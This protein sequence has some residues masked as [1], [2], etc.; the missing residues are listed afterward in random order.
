MAT[1]SNFFRDF[2][3]ALEPPV[4]QHLTNVY[5]CLAL[6]TVVAGFGAYVDLVTKL[7]STSFIAAIAGVGL[8][9]GVTS[10]HD[11]GKNRY[12]RLGLLLGF[13]FCSGLGLGTLIDYAIT[14][15]PSIIVTA[16]ISTAAIFI[17]FSVA[18]L[19]AERGRWLY[20]GG[21]LMTF[22]AVLIGLSFAN[23]FFGSQLLFQTYLYL[24]LALMCGFVLYDT[25][26]IIEKR[27]H[28]DKDFI[29]HS[30]DLFVDLLG[31]FRRIV[32]ILIQKEQQQQQ[33]KKKRKN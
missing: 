6:S 29:S 28:G 15:N 24:G 14:I 31:I 12:L 5:A 25:Q 17:C 22:L 21:T 13:S 4:R 9:L 18:S 20:L 19:T 26:L 8:L 33:S 2:N 32:I 11:N 30:I 10:T 16:L 27:R 7:S 1:F 3:R 23:I